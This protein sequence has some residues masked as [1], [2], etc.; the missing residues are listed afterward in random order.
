MKDQIKLYRRRI[1]GVWRDFA[2]GDI[3][4]FI[5]RE[6]SLNRVRDGQRAGWS[7]TEAGRQANLRKSC[8]N[9]S[10]RKPMLEDLA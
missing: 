2:G 4:W 7:S 6:E 5:Q 1:I 10:E 9:S 3:E 8:E